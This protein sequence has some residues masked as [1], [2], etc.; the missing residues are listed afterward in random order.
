[1]ILFEAI[2]YFALIWALLLMIPEFLNYIKNNN[3]VSCY[4]ETM[5]KKCTTFWL[6]LLITLNPFTAAIASFI[7]YF[8]D[9]YIGEKDIK[10]Y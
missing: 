10:L 7:A 9:I 3:I 2:K 6:T 5:C 4:I 8:V 1:M